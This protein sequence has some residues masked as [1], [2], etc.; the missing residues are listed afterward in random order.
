MLLSLVTGL[1]KRELSYGTEKKKASVVD[2]L[3]SFCLRL[4]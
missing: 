2:M 1:N 4:L 3:F